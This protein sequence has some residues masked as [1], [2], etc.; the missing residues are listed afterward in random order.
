MEEEYFS[1]NE[2]CLKFKLSHSTIYKKIKNNEIPAFK[3][4]RC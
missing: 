1:V 2:V 3:L 4:G